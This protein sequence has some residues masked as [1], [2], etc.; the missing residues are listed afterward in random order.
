MQ[1]TQTKE[2]IKLAPNEN[3]EQHDSE[4]QLLYNWQTYL[5]LWGKFVVLAPP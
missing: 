2:K 4:H 3:E 1:L 5:M